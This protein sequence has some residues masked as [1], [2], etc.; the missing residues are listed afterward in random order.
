MNKIRLLGMAI[1]LA[2]VCAGITACSKSSDDEKADE[3]NNYKSLIIGKWKLR[4]SDDTYA[5]IATHVEFKKDGTFSLTTTKEEWSGY[6]EHGIYKIDGD[7]LYMLFSD[8]DDWGMRKIIL[9]DSMSLIYKKIRD[10]GEL[11]KT[12]YSFQ[13]GN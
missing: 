8:E 4:I 10:N 9:L 7:I 1:L 5:V 2:L 12:A 3:G 11:S 6:E 13:K